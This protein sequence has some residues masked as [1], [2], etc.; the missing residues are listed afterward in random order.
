MFQSMTSILT[1][2]AMLLHSIL[3]CC[4]HHAHACEHG[5]AVET[6]DS[7]HDEHVGHHRDRDVHKHG[8]QHQ[9]HAHHADSGCRHK[10][11]V[12]AEDIEQPLMAESEHEDRR[13]PAC[14]HAPCEHDCGS[15]DC[16]FTQTSNVRTPTPDDARAGLSGVFASAH[17]TPMSVGISATFADSGPPGLSVNCCDRPLLQVWRL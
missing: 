2:S 8:S 13:L 6:C 9:G 10:T 7:G 4:S 12:T 15:G 17:V 3:G 5:H 16:S 14:P 11:S 1:M